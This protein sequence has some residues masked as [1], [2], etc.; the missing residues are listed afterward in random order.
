[1]SNLIN[2]IR[3]L[4]RSGARG[5]WGGGG[6]GGRGGGGG[7][8]QKEWIRDKKERNNALSLK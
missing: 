1:M 5:V 4:V 6:G 7:G 3:S 8:V 2:N